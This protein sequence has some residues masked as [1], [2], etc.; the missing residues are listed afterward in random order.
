VIRVVV[1]ASVAV[2][3]AYPSRDDEADA[4][5]ALA[6]LDGYRKGETALLQPPHWLAEIA[7]VVARQSPETTRQYLDVLYALRVPVAGGLEVYL[8]ACELAIATGQ[9]VFDTLYHAVALLTPECTLVTADERYY[10]KARTK[11]SIVLLRDF[12]FPTARAEDERSDS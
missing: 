12:D 7:A 5:K 3:W 1:D 6:L 9:H 10:D 2:K 8:Q 4:A 11:G